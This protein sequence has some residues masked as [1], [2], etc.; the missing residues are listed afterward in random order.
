MRRVV[1][2]EFNFQP[3]H[4]LGMFC[5]QFRIISPQIVPTER[6]EKSS[7]SKATDKSSRCDGWVWWVK[8]SVV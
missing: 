7:I 2:S 1:G 4:P 5:E 8:T 3:S 6:G